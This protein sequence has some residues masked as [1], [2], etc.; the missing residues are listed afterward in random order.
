MFAYTI[1]NF[2]VFHSRF[3]FWR[4][5]LSR[6]YG[7]RNSFFIAGCIL[8]AAFPA[9]HMI[10]NM[11]LLFLFNI[12]AEALSAGVG[13]GIRIKMGKGQENIEDRA[14]C[15]MGLLRD[16]ESRDSEVS[17]PKSSNPKISAFFGD[18]DRFLDILGF[19]PTPEEIFRKVLKVDTFEGR[20]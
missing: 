2:M 16:L 18:S 20:C 13:F 6:T 14:G 9:L 10:Q 4:A 19:F 1:A 15:G 12:K 11:F 5:Y 8:Y 17:F 7:E 3:E